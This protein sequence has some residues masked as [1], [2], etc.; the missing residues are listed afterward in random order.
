MAKTKAKK[1]PI[2]KSVDQVLDENKAYR[3]LVKDVTNLNEM[4]SIHSQKINKLDTLTNECK[5]I[6]D[7]MRGRLGV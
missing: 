4:I 7:T 1:E 3:D 5:A 2:V 6:I